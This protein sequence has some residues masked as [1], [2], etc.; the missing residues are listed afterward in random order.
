MVQPEVIIVP[1]V[2]GM[3]TLVLLMKM[4]LSYRERRERQ[5]AVSPA[6]ADAI[7]ARLERLEQAVDSIAVEV[8]RV[9]EGQRFATRLLSER[10]TPAPPDAVRRAAGRVVTPH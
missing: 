3:P 8:E 4:W 10:G 7:L 9:G 6:V 2:F 1:V 5:A